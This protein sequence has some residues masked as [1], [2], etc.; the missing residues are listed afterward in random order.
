M[1]LTNFDFTTLDEPIMDNQPEVVTDVEYDVDPEPAGTDDTDEIPQPA[2]SKVPYSTE[3]VSRILREGNFDAIDTSRLSEE[4]QLVMRAMQSGL[5]PKLQEAAEI[6]K[7]LDRVRQE[8]EASKPKAQPRD[9][10]EAFDQDP[11]NVVSYIN[12]EIK[13]LV[14]N[15]P[16]ANAV[17][18]EQ[19]RDLKDELR[20][21]ELQ[22]IQETSTKK[23]EVD[24]YIQQ[25]AKIVPDIAAKQHALVKFAVEVMGYS[26]EELNYE[27]NP[28]LVGE[29]AVKTVA[30]I[31]QAYDRF[32]AGRTIKQKEVKPTPTKVE[33]AGKGFERETMNSRELLE[34]AKRTGNWRDL[35]LHMDE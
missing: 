17:Q 4:G 3:E 26:P 15:D 35:F 20:T 5:T 21:R 8:L 10:Y 29:R 30:R 9:I 6:R 24:G 19:L 33:P 23:A 16:I 27:T 25:I 1:S 18:I 31:N 7:E 34:N 22:R 32:N 11:Q 2:Q 14:A 28:G 13:A 12:N